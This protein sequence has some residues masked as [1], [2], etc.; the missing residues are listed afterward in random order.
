MCVSYFQI[1]F[2]IGTAPKCN[3]LQT[4]QI[5]VSNS[6]VALCRM[7]LYYEFKL[8][9]LLV[10]QNTSWKIPSII[11][12]R[13]LRPILEPNEPAIDEFL[14][15]SWLNMMMGI[16]NGLQYL[17]QNG[18]SIIATVTAAIHAAAD[19]AERTA[20]EE[21]QKKLVRK[22]TVNAMHGKLH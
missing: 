14:S 20:R 5:I 6:F 15:R 7:P 13:F 4:T 9:C 2:C 22:N 10:L 8:V 21:H 12:N 16:S 1:K 17:L 3:F 18:P 19:A 11:F